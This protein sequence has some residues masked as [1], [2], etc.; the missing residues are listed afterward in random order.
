MLIDL[1]QS[2]EKKIDKIKGFSSIE[3][4]GVKYLK[5]NSKQNNYYLQEIVKKEKIVLHHTVGNIYGDFVTLTSQN[6]VSV[7][8]LIS[9]N[10]TVLELFNPK[11]WSYHL[12][13]TALGGNRNQSKISIGIELSNYGYLLRKDDTLYTIYGSEYCKITD[14][15]HYE[16]KEYRGQKYWTKYTEEQY[17]ALRKLLVKLTNEYNIPYEFLPVNERMDYT[18]KVIN[19]KGIVTHINY[20]KDKWDVSPIFNWSKISN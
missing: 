14:T 1:L 8:Y 16:V 20:R 9:G 2:F 19:F 12:G 17:I 15:D 18:K 7:A 13:R 4:D 6:Q 11:Y 3:E 5:Y 10:G